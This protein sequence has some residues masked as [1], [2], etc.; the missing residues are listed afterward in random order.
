MK[1]CW[2]WYFPRIAKLLDQEEIREVHQDNVYT[3]VCQPVLVLRSQAFF[4]SLFPA[5]PAPKVQ[6]EMQVAKICRADKRRAMMLY[7]LLKVF[8]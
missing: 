7:H 5:S 3:G 6:D 1:K 2:G 8:I 4:I